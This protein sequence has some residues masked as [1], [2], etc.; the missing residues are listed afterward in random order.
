MTSLG[1]FWALR[2]NHRLAARASSHATGACAASS[3]VAAHYSKT[4]ISRANMLAFFYFRAFGCQP[5]RALGREKKAPRCDEQSEI[6]QSC[7][8]NKNYL[9]NSHP[10]LTPIA[11]A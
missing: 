3:N 4:V 9:I 8:T 7:P 1:C 10:E 5:S 11:S 6:K 2:E